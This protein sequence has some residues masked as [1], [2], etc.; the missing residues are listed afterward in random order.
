MRANPT[1][2]NFKATRSTCERPGSAEQTSIL[3]SIRVSPQAASSRTVARS[4]SERA[5]WGAPDSEA[6]H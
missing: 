1:Y 6:S 4:A 3:V 2:W 5:S